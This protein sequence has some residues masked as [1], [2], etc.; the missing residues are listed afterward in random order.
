MTPE[1]VAVMAEWLDAANVDLKAWSDD[2]YRRTCKGRLEPVKTSIR[3]LREAGVHVEV[4]TLLVTGENDSP[5]DL[6]GIA[7][8]LAGLGTDLVWHVSRY[9][10][11]F[12]ATAPPTPLAT[13]ERALEIGR[14]AG[15]QFVYAGNI[16]GRQDT[17]CP[18][19]G[20]T[21]I[22]RRGLE[23]RIVN[24]RGAACGRCGAALPIRMG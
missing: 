14:A 2:F 4:T 23:G 15:L 24:L 22:E 7:G 17:R 11:D 8:Y 1:A 5:E 16:A 13:M 20:E 10:P 3:L 9:H 19:C 21:V 18:A 6:R 12:Q